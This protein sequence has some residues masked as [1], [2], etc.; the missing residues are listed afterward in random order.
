M[1]IDP[2]AH[3]SIAD[4]Q[5]ALIEV[6]QLPSRTS[7]SRLIESRYIPPLRN[8]KVCTVQPPSL[9][10][11]LLLYHFRCC[12]LHGMCSCLPTVG[13]TYSLSG[14]R[15]RSRWCRHIFICNIVDLDVFE[16]GC[17]LVNPHTSTLFWRA[18]RNRT[19]CL[20]ILLGRAV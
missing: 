19:Q 16:V 2:Q 15:K 3:T 13:F 5:R 9:T 6:V 12:K 14:Q 8:P 11:T 17:C 10:K 18:E 4:N 1:S 20:E 7:L